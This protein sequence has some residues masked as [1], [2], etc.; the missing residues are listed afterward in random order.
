MT[1]SRYDISRQGP[2][3]GRCRWIL[4]TAEVIGTGFTTCSTFV[5][6]CLVAVEADVKVLS[7][8]FCCFFF[9]FGGGGFSGTRPLG[10]SLVQVLAFMMWLN[11]VSCVR[12]PLPARQ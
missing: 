1:R 10:L 9:F 4:G 6:D 5:T 12:T 2:T 8:F 11:R 3:A 7:F